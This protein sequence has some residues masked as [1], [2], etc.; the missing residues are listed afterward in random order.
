MRYVPKEVLD[1]LKRIDLLTY[2]KLACPEEIVN[3]GNGL[4]TT[5][6]HDSLKI[7]NGFWNWFSR[8]Y[9]GKNAIDF[10]MK[11]E[12][13]CFSKAVEL[14]MKRTNIMMDNYEEYILKLPK[15]I[16]KKEQVSKKVILPERNE[17]N[18]IHSL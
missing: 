9:G 3:E 1:N 8:G 13:V 7:S 10:I 15:N 6:T 5:K 4:Y 14:L 16:E 18:K 2:F 17:D 12:N 11:T